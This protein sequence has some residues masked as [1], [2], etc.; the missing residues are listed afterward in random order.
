VEQPEADQDQATA[1]CALALVSRGDDWTEFGD[2]SR[3][4]HWSDGRFCVALLIPAASIKEAYVPQVLEV[5]GED[6]KVLSACWADPE[7][8]AIGLLPMSLASRW[9]PICRRWRAGSDA[10]VADR[11]GLSRGR[12]M[13]GPLPEP[14]RVPGECRRRSDHV[15]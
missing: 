9:R 2:G 5:W 7:E 4:G 14:L 1:I 3:V 11:G 6:A 10:S 15:Y 13:R 8:L 12:N